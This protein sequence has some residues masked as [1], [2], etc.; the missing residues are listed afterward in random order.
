MGQSKQK[1]D[2]I[3]A[4]LA[5]L[6]EISQLAEKEGEAIERAMLESEAIRREVTERPMKDV[7]L[8][9]KYRTRVGLFGIRLEKLLLRVDEVDSLG[10][11]EEIRQRRKQAV[12]RM[13][14][15]LRN[16]DG[17]NAVA[18][19]LVVTQDKLMQR[20]EDDGAL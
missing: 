14:A 5:R 15:L 7:L 10:G 19:E 1:E 20:V 3:A 17:L 2:E 13:E 12:R 18:N 16:A 8:A 4:Q 6:E 9:R 11:V